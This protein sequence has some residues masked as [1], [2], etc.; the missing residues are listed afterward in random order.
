MQ[1]SSVSPKFGVSLDNDEIQAPHNLNIKI[2]GVGGGGGS[3]VAE[4]A[5]ANIEGVDLWAANTDSQALE[6]LR[7]Q[8]G[9]NALSLGKERNEG[10]GGNPSIG[11]RVAIETQFEILTILEDTRLVFI[12][13]CMGGGTGTGA[14]PVIARCAKERGILTVGVVTRPR[15]IEQRTAKADQGV[16]EMRNHCHALM[17]FPNDNAFPQDQDLDWKT[18]VGTINQRL[19]E[20]IRV[21][22]DM[23]F[24][25]G[26]I[27]RD[28]RDLE[29]CIPVGSEEAVDL[30]IG[31]AESDGVNRIEEIKNDLLDVSLHDIALSEMAYAHIINFTTNPEDSASAKDSEMQ[32]VVDLIEG[33]GDEDTQR[34]IGIY[35]SANVR[36]GALR[37]SL[38]MPMRRNAEEV[39]DVLLKPVEDQTKPIL[40]AV[41]DIEEDTEEPWDAMLDELIATST[42]E[43]TESLNN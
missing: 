16:E 8:L 36:G 31:V 41:E 21:V 34:F 4:C 32:E 43:A 30:F 24:Q 17:V 2:I 3:I 12:V 1:T 20:S 33:T 13:A 27:N 6:Q 9:V 38:I 39:H 5:R 29:T 14:A 23:L 42:D 7:S 19:V 10:A 26:I 15:T 28:F 18:A 37:V 11:E 22:T 25:T 35:E 40:H